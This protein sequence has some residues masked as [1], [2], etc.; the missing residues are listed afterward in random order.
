[1]SEI[2]LLT[3][4]NDC[5]MVTCKTNFTAEEVHQFQGHLLDS[6]TDDI[7]KVVFDLTE[8]TYLDSSGIGLLV[9]C[10]NSMNLLD[11][12]V[13]IRNVS[14]NIYRLLSLMRLTKRINV[15]STQGDDHG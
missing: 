3:V 8:T 5:L 14:E 10:H 9:A 6:I 7:S 12:S 4:N 1:M 15:T 13:E 2:P 11:G